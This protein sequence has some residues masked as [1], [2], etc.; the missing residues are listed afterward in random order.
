M[1]AKTETHLKSLRTEMEAAKRLAAN[2]RSST[3]VAR[4]LA[5]EGTDIEIV[6]LAAV[7]GIV[8]ELIIICWTLDSFQLAAAGFGYLLLVFTADSCGDS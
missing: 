1:T 7:S 3:A 4:R 8:V 2:A 6:T 5:E